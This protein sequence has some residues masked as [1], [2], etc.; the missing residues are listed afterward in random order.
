MRFHKVLVLLIYTGVLQ[1]STSYSASAQSCLDFYSH[2]IQ[3]INLALKG[4]ELNKV[5]VNSAIGAVGL[6]LTLKQIP[7]WQSISPFLVQTLKGEIVSGLI[8]HDDLTAST[9]GGKIKDIEF[10][11]DPSVD[12]R[13]AAMRIYVV[14]ITPLGTIQKIQVSDVVILNV[15]QYKN[16]AD[17]QK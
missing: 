6:D 2:E 12:P 13:Y 8:R 7:G 3:M 15:Y 9:F 10:N 5:D 16:N 4:V 14:V 11:Q 1:L 17:S